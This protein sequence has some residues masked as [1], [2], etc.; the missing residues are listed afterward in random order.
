MDLQFIDALKKHIRREINYQESKKIKSIFKIWGESLQ[1]T[2][3]NLHIIHIK[4]N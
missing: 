3:Q 1:K 2:N 4:T